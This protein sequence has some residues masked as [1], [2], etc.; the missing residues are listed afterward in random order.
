MLGICY[1]PSNQITMKAGE[2]LF[3]LLKEVLGQRNLASQV[4]FI[5]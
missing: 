2:T 1:W 5:I 3:F 4:S